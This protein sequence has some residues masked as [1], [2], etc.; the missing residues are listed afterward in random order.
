MN[1]GPKR[2]A[3]AVDFDDE[4]AE[5]SIVLAQEIRGQRIVFG[6]AESATETNAGNLLTAARGMRLERRV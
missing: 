3:V 4:G 1:S 5:E 2:R 6:N